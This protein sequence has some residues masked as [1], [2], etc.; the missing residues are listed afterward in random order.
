MDILIETK[1]TRIAKIAKERPQEKFTSLYHLLNEDMLT[2]CHFELESG[3]ANGV[4]EVTKEEYEQ[5]LFQ[6]IKDLVDRLKRHSYKPQPAR[7]VYIPK[8]NG[9]QRPLG[10]PAYED[11]IVQLGLKKILEAIYEPYFMEFSYGF[12]PKRSCHDAL[13]EIDR[14]IKKKKINYIV[15]VDIKGFF[16]NVNHEWLIKFIGHRITDPNIKRLIV[17]FLKAGI[18]EG[19]IFK[20]TDKGTPQGGLC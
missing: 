18:V 14:I 8:G 20:I 1:L 16:D 12:R 6:N 2:L 19:E 7:R 17:K 4:D 15:D 10:I 9:K 13:K 11:K 5:N 3:K